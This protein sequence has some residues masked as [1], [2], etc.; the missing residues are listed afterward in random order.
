MRPLGQIFEDRM[1]EDEPE[2][3]RRLKIAKLSYL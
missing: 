1:A 3:F 2:D